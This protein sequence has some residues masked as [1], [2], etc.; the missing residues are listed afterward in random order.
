V[1]TRSDHEG[2]LLNPNRAP[3]RSPRSLAT[4]IAFDRRSFSCRRGAVGILMFGAQS[5]TDTL[6]EFAR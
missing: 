6:T 2:A 4:S 1:G 3:V 5:I